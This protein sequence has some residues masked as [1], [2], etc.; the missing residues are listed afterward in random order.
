MY[1]I[2]WRV[3]QFGHKPRTLEWFC[4]LEV[5]NVHVYVRDWVAWFWVHT[6]MLAES[7]TL[8]A[9]LQTN[10]HQGDWDHNIAVQEQADSLRAFFLVIYDDSDLDQEELL[11]LLLALDN[12]CAA[13]L[14]PFQFAF[15]LLQKEDPIAHWR[16]HNPF[17]MNGSVITGSFTGFSRAELYYWTKLSLARPARANWR[18][19]PGQTKRTHSLARVFAF[20]CHKA[21][22][23]TFAYHY[24][25]D[26]RMLMLQQKFS[27]GRAAACKLPC[28][29]S[30]DHGSVFF[31][32]SDFQFA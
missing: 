23:I 14:P 24:P 17:K 10:F 8:A 25:V 7:S 21:F 13:L 1:K 16:I 11:V 27:S 12:V 32:L 3:G 15:V 31:E 9:V 20:T 29:F 5:I 28:K 22:L 4:K 2:W 19:L 30:E 26:M 18:P 6:K